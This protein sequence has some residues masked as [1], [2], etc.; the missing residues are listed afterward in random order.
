ML[1]TKL[2]NNVFINIINSNTWLHIQVTID[3]LSQMHKKMI[4]YTIKNVNA[5]SIVCNR[6]YALRK[7]LFNLKS[8]PRAFH[9]AADAVFLC[10]YAIVQMA[11]FIS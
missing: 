8:D 6:K 3:L 11:D 9:Y 1:L 4:I 2:S 7:L 5:M 10:P